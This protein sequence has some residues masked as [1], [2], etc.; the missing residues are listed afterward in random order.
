MSKID[1]ISRNLRKQMDVMEQQNSDARDMIIAVTPIRRK[2]LKGIGAGRKSDAGRRTMEAAFSIA[3]PVN[4][5]VLGNAPFRV[6]ALKDTQS[7]TV[8]KWSLPL[9]P[10]TRRHI[11]FLVRCAMGCWS[12]G[13]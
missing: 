2:V 11:I 4:S 1:F 8:T 3:K 9:D 12:H 5:D 13:L 6:I 7:E 10:D